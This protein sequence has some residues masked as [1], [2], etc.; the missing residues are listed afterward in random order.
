MDRDSDRFGMP[1]S[2]FDAA[3]ESHGVNN[4]T[5]RCGMN[6]PT[7]HEVATLP[8]EELS[9]IIIDWMWESPSQLIPSN[10]QIEEVKAVLTNRSDVE[11][12]QAAGLIAECDAYL[13][14]R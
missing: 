5:I 2:A 4:P 3:R 12:D 9:S 10:D 6:V 8:I 14:V 1:Q 11:T 13:R 7:R